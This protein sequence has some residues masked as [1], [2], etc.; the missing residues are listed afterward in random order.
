MCRLSTHQVIFFETNLVSYNS[1][2]F[3]HYLLGDSIWSPRLRSQCYRCAPCPHFRRQWQVQVTTCASDQLALD[4][5]FP[6]LPPPGDWFAIVAQRTQGNIFLDHWFTIRGN[7]LT[8]EMRRARY[9]GRAMEL[10][11]FLWACH[12]PCIS[13]R[14]TPWKLST[15]HSFGVLWK[16]YYST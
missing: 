14:S 5:R 4:W 2:Q 16:F 10:P 13:M 8:E 9:V 15:P 1:I 3:Q 7:S 12:P 11:C 6:G